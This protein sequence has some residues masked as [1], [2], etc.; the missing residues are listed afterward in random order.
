MM[1]ILVRCMAS[2]LGPDIRRAVDGDEHKVDAVRSDFGLLGLTMYVRGLADD[3]DIGLF[4][5]CEGFDRLEDGEAIDE[6]IGGVL[7]EAIDGCEATRGEIETQVNDR[8]PDDPICTRLV[9]RLAVL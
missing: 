9:P 8:D 1:D 7:L 6:M 2:V 5:L 4:E 3:P